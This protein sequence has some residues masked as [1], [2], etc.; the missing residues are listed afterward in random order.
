MLMKLIAGGKICS[1]FC[2]K[3]F[4]NTLRVNHHKFVGLNVGNAKP[5]LAQGQKDTGG[6]KFT[7]LLKANSL[8]LRNF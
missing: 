2:I 4:F 8:D 3:P 1:Y 7:K 5:I 6:L